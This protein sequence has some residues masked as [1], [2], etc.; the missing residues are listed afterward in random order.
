M[1]DRLRLI[2][3]RGVLSGS[4]DDE[5]QLLIER[6]R[7]GELTNEQLL[8]AGVAGFTSASLALGMSA[9]AAAAEING[10][11]S[12]CNEYLFETIID[13]VRIVGELNNRL[14]WGFTLND[15]LTLP[16]PMHQPAPGEHG[17]ST[18]VLVPYLDTV[19]ET[20]DGLWKA[21]QSRH[22]NTYRWEQS[23]SDPDN[24]RLLEG[25]THFGKC[26][27][28]EAIDLGAN[29][30]QENG[31]APRDVRN[32]QSPH[33][34]VLAAAAL[35]TKWVEA[36]DGTTVPYVWLPGYQC[37]VNARWSAVPWLHFLQFLRQVQLCHD[38]GGNHSQNFAVPAC[39]GV[40]VGPQP[41]EL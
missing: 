41:S 15:F 7:A 37:N 30:D 13:Q 3:R 26:L 8:V 20:F 4:P 21:I 24:L 14:G 9:E 12:V 33:A 16:L 40:P 38:G 32:T 5:A 10:P 19:Q 2:Q 29:W 1:D 18:L 36:M 34:G 22:T 39:L 35:H 25:I 17:L 6:L 23:K 31:I 28:W 27:Q 11:P